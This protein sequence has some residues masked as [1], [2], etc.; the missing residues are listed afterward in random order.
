MIQ[1][2][3]D[4][5]YLLGHMKSLANG[6]LHAEYPYSLAKFGSG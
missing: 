5:T 6:Y 4:E 1:N 2:A 3:V